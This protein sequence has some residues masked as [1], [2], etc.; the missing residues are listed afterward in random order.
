ML[1]KFKKITLENGFE[2]YYVPVNTGSDVVSVDLFYKVGSR[3]ETMGKSGIAHM[4]E[5]MN[6]KSTRNHPAG[7]FDRIVKGFGGVDNAS[8][9]FDFTHYFIKCASS[10]LNKSV[11]LFADMMENL[12]L[13]DKEFQPE[14]AVVA[15]ERRWRTDNSPIGILYFTLFNEAFSYHPYHWTP[16][17][18]MEDIQSWSINDIREFHATY[19][20]PKNAFLIISGDI[21]EKEAFNTAK[22]Y[23]APIKNKREIPSF[24]FKEP[25]QKG[26]KKVIIRKESDVE[27]FA[28]AYKIPPYDHADSAALAALGE[29]LSGGKSS[30]LEHRLGNELNLANAV[31]AFVMDCKDEGLF[32]VLCVCN[33]GV[34]AEKVEKEILN[35]IK[36]C[37]KNL[38]DA[39]ELAKIKNS[40][41]FEFAYSL[42]SAS[43]VAEIYGSYIAR[44]D[45]APLLSLQEDKENLTA[46]DLRKVAKKY[47]TEDKSTTVILKGIK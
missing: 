23:F 19:Y 18:F 5:H 22:K 42:A 8:T 32:I 43:S 26:A 7:E 20:Q 41:K 1:P 12:S 15:E 21:S 29:Y 37:K 4:L 40:L 47:F 46:E 13:K 33:A 17:G 16:I 6:F 14:R 9:G 27:I 36:S 45:V 34:K 11:E 2:I 10:N 44:G 31:D 3:N 25:E 28:L 38:A 39:D 30:L 35:L 24:K